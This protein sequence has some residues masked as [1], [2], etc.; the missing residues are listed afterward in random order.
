MNIMRMRSKLPEKKAAKMS[1]K[2]IA[3]GCMIG[4]SA[5]C[6]IIFG[7]LWKVTPLSD[8]FIVELGENVSLQPG[9]YFS[10]RAWSVEKAEIDLSEVVLTEPGSYS[11][12]GYH[13]LETYTF[14][15]IIQDTTPPEI[16]EKTGVIYLQAGNEYT[17]YDL[18]DTVT[19]LSGNVDLWIEAEGQVTKILSYEDTG[20]YTV[21]V[22]AT[23]P[24]GNTAEC[25]VTFLVDTAPEITGMQEA[26]VA[27]GCEVSLEEFA[28]GVT[29]Y[30]EIDGEL[31]EQILIDTS[32]INWNTAGEYQVIYSVTDGYGL[33]GVNY[34]NVYVLSADQLQEA[35]NT[36]RI[37]RFNQIIEGA[38]NLYDAGYY[39]DDDPE[40]IMEAMKPAFVRI[41]MSET[42]H[43]SGFII[44]ITDDSIMI[45]TNQHVVKNKETME[46]CFHNG[47]HAWGNVVA[48]EER[49][50][51]GFVEVPFD[52]ITPEL[53][54][55]LLTVHIDMDYWNALENRDPISLCMR[56]LNE[57]GSVWHDRTGML[58]QKVGE[59]P[60]FV[61]RYYPGQ[62]VPLMTEVYLDFYTGC[63]GSAILDGHGNLI[64]MAAAVT[65]EDDEIRE[66]AVLLSDILNY[67]EEVMGRTANYK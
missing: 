46:V 44:E 49:L 13:G 28:Q 24:A 52:N 20:T 56:T 2:T 41:N 17:P 39:E 42:I 16:T 59:Q 51:I 27:E 10:G 14:T 34:S 1:K 9:D 65:E 23:D 29:A 50:D 35:I 67:Y 12:Y 64:A 5:V 32:A 36:H 4:L 31:T 38:Y 26:Y 48:S 62:E 61:A 11:V 7:H 63:S 58:V 45:C 40:F 55:S 21:I 66:W 15:V 18:I 57:D 30:D 6:G 8:S 37:N 19:D 54:D 25:Q 47:V 43:G 53:L 22:R 60:E 3:A 33:T